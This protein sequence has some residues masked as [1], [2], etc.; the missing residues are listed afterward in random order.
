LGLYYHSR[1]WDRALEEYNLALKLDPNYGVAL[2]QLGYMYAGREDFEKALEYFQRYAA[3]SPGDANPLDSLAELYFKMGDLDKAITKYKE[4]L[5]VKP[6]FFDTYWRIGYMYALRE[7]YAEAMSWI[8]QFIDVAP[9]LGVKAE[10]HFW[11]GFYHCLLGKFDQ[12]LLDFREGAE[13]FDKAGD[14]FR[15][16][17][18]SWWNGWIYFDK[19]EFETGREYFKIWK[20]FVNKYFPETSAWAQIEAYFYFGLV[21]LKLDR[22][23]SAKSRLKEMKTVLPKLKTYK[24]WITF[25]YVLFNGEVMLAEGN[26]EECISYCEKE[27]ASKIPSWAVNTLIAYNI[28][29]LRDVLARAYQQ[30]GEIEKAIVEYERLITF[31][32]DSQNR[33]LVHPKNYYRLARLYE[34]QGNT[35]KAIENYEKF[36]SLWKDADPDLPEVEDAKKR[37]RRGSGLTS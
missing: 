34:Q 26:L 3:S 8:D 24:S 22:L 29:F 27:L 32:P 31:D 36:L 7:D 37:L 16:N 28:P 15:K 13:L 17:F 33:L 30:N 35:A 6:D 11:K 19:R 20:D 21:D 23:D 5:E 25:Q 18:A 1:D 2:N 9:S 4:A 10:G 14:E 12:A